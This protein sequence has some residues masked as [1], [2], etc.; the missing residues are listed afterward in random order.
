MV[1]PR[2]ACSERCAVIFPVLTA[3][4]MT[5][6]SKVRLSFFKFHDLVSNGSCIFLQLKDI[7]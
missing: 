1:Q 2:M 4:H 3:H 7:M 5:E 6:P